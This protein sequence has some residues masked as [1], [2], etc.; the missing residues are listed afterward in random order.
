MTD[1]LVDVIIIPEVWPHFIQILWSVQVCAALCEESKARRQLAIGRRLIFSPASVRG[2]GEFSMKTS[3]RNYAWETILT[4]IKNLSCT[5]ST[6]Q[7]ILQLWTLWFFSSTALICNEVIMCV[8]DNSAYQAEDCD[9][10]GEIFW[11]HCMIKH[12]KEKNRVIQDY[13]KPLKHISHIK[14]KVTSSMLPL[15]MFCQVAIATSAM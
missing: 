2:D 1:L 10:K 8:Y 15:E 4:I 11:L 5:C 7:R 3:A 13:H 9:I 14:I 12:L 6:Q